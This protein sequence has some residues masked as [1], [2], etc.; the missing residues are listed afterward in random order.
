MTFK[1]ETI[2]PQI[3]AEYLSHN[4]QNNRNLRRDYVEMLAR[5]MASGSF[6][7]T[8]QGIAFDENGNLIDGQHRLHAVLLSGTPVRMVVARGLVTDMVNSIDKGSQR[9]LHDTMMITCVGNDEKSRAMRHR[10]VLNAIAMTGRL[11]VNNIRKISAREAMLVFENY[12]D[13][14]LSLYKS[15]TKGIGRKSGV[16]LAACLAALIN[17]VPE[18]TVR[19]FVQVFR[20]ADI[21]GC[22]Q[23]N[24]QIVLS[25]RRYLDG[26]RAKH[27]RI[28]EDAAYKTMKFVLWN[29]AN[30][31]RLP[32]TQ[33]VTE[34]KYP[35]REEFTALLK[36]RTA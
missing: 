10:D 1:I 29:F 26:L 14:C 13:A 27:M 22:E 11:N 5:D 19:K 3:A 4:V 28:N 8:H 2:T 36:R 31:T 25:W 20:D 7:C 17:G 30:N 15:C 23:Y 21:T 35:V 9:S 16:Q 12:E 18:E 24:V 6:R 34:E 32:K 33:L